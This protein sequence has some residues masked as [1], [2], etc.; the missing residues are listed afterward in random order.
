[1]IL[2]NKYEP[3]ISIEDSFQQCE[4]AYIELCKIF[5]FIDLPLNIQ[6][7]EKQNSA[8]L[9]AY[10][11]NALDNNLVDIKTVK[12]L[13]NKN[14]RASNLSE[15]AI[16]N[17]SQA[18]LFLSQQTHQPLSLALLY[19]TQRILS[20][21][22]KEATTEN[23]LFSYP[24]NTEAEKISLESEIELESLFEFLNDDSE[25]HPIVQ[26]WILHFRIRTISLFN[27]GNNKLASLLQQ[28]WLSKNQM[29]LF[30][31]LSL[32]HE[33]YIQKIEYEEIIHLSKVGD[34]GSLNAQIEFGLQLH[35]F[36]LERLKDL[37]KSYFRKQV[38][39]EKLNPRQKNIMNYVFER[40]YRLKEIDDAILN[41]R[42]KL[43]MYI[44]QHRGFISTKELVNEFDCNRKTIQRDF[45]LLMD[46]NLV[47]SIGAGAGLR[48]C[49]NL[50]ENRNPQLEKYQADFI[51][52][53][54]SEDSQIE[55]EL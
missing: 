51:K 27:E 24:N 4:R 53:I 19:E 28:F 11:A 6:Q 9:R 22:K 40:G 33:L 15:Q 23:N 20:G 31:L 54:P 7:I 42:Q 46:L 49:I 45:Q 50:Q 34:L 48:Y 41:K 25:F 43:I 47:K 14:L 10:Y 38:D 30:G 3:L 29:D 52:T 26:S 36:Q 18:E 37:F 1:M 17:F 35:Q 16:E 5:D 32:E 8:I 55:D 21:Q 2:I 12:Y 39:F 44:V 13:L